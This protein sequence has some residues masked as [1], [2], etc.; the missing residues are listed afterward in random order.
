MYSGGFNQNLIH[1]TMI[2][3]GVMERASTMLAFKDVPSGF[4][5]RNVVP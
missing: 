4:L 3:M 1:P 2:A 5:H